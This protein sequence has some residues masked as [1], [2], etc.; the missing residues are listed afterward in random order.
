MPTRDLQRRAFWRPDLRRLILTLCILSVLLALAGS[1]HASYRVQRDTLL[2]NTLEANRVYT[3]K[4]ASTTE[5]FLADMVLQLSY[6]AGVLSS[7]FNEA[8]ALSRETRRLQGQSSHFNSVVVVRADNRVIAAWPNT[9]DLVGRT[10]DS[11]GGRAAMAARTPLVSQ[12]YRGV[13]NTWL[14]FVSC[15]I[16]DDQG[17]FLGYVGGSILLHEPNVL[18]A[19]LGRHPYRDGSSLYVTDRTGVVIYHPDVARIGG[20]ASSAVLDASDAQ[21][22]GGAALTSSSG[23]TTLVGWSQVESTGWRVVA[24]RPLAS[25]LS[26]LESLMWSTVS[27]AL[28]LVMLLLLVI[29]WVSRQIAFPLWEM[30]S[31]ARRLDRKETSDQIRRVRSWYFEA[32]QLKRALLT[33]LSSFTYKLTDLRRETATDPL[34]GLLNRRGTSAVLAQLQE[35]GLPFAVVSIDIDHFKRINDTLG[36]DAGDEVIRQVAVLMQQHSRQQDALCRNGGEEFVMLLPDT[37]P[38]EAVGVAER[39]RV[40]MANSPHPTVDPITVSIGIA[41]FPET[42][43]DVAEVLKEADNALYAAKRGGRNRTVCAGM[44][45]EGSVS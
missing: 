7:T 11:A 24:Q 34:T 35:S 27:G 6:A 37:T 19:L 9:R 22:D 5:L 32:A 45:S 8:Q 21:S 36:H 38:E 44:S 42:A 29:W 31:L 26:R 30:A 4:V 16:I 17:Q 3:A 28:P 1:F 41:H 40:A 12:P 33:G 10:L 43:V 14:I 20:A 13:N 2:E 18:H 25:T 39:L 15:P 23:M